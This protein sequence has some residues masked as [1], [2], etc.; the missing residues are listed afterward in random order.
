[1]VG[2]ECLGG[3]TLRPERAELG[4]QGGVRLQD[5]L[6]EFG[7][8][9]TF[10][11]ERHVV[12][13]LEDFIAR[14]QLTHPDLGDAG[15]FRQIAQQSLAIITCQHRCLF[16]DVGYNLID[17]WLLRGARIGKS[18]FVRFDADLQGQ[19]RWI[20]AAEPAAGTKV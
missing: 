19:R 13:G 4:K 2:R 20:G 1:M 10:G 17:K 8:G 12:V 11:G 3:E 16:Q 9:Q 6:G 14:G 15:A 18:A 5:R 7:G